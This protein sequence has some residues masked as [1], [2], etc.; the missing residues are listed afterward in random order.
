M[1]KT[2]LKNL[3]YLPVNVFGTI[4]LY[5]LRTLI[6]RLLDT[7]P[8]LYVYVVVGATR[9]SSRLQWKKSEY[10]PALGIEPATSRSV[11]KRSTDLA[12]RLQ[13]YISVITQNYHQQK[14]NRKVTF[15]Q[16]HQA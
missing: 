15:A 8:P 4:Y 12:N 7:G 10:C 14:L 9:R 2:T 13:V 1:D 16:S 3:L 6:L 5:L 11:V